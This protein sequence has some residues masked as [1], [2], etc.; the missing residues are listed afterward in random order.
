LTPTDRIYLREIRDKVRIEQE[1]NSNQLDTP[2]GDEEPMG[3][4]PILHEYDSSDGEEPM[5]I[6]PRLP[7]YELQRTRREPVYDSSDE[8]NDDD[9]QSQTVLLSGEREWE[10]DQTAVEWVIRYMWGETEDVIQNELLNRGYTDTEVRYVLDVVSQ[11]Q[12]FCFQRIEKNQYRM[13]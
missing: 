1:N 13:N 10:L 3:I 7:E 6:Q 9:D 8:E 4:Q 11:A 5:G 12:P 2:R